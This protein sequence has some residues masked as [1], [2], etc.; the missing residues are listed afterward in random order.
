MKKVFSLMIFFFVLCMAQTVYAA[1]NVSLSSNKSS[2]KVGEEFSVSVSLS[3]A[4]VA[5]LTARITIDTSKV[6]YVSGPSNSSFRNGRMIYTW[7]DPNGGET[8]K[9]SGVLATFKLKAKAAGSAGFSVSGDFYTPEETAVNP[10]FSGTTVTII[11]EAPEKPIE[12]EVPQAPTT[13]EVPNNP[14]LPSNP[15]VPNTPETPTTPEVPST[16]SQGTTTTP[17]TNP[18]Q[19]G[20]TNLSSNANLKSL[21]L[22]VQGMTPAFQRDVLQYGIVVNETVTDVDVLAVAEDSNSSIQITGNHG[23]QMGNNTI[24]ITVTAQNG[25]K[26]TYTISVTKTNEAN[27]A[28]SFLENLAIENVALTPDFRYD[29]LEYTAEIESNIESLNVLAV[30]QRE[31]AKVVIEGRENLQ[32]GENKITVTVTAEDGITT[33]NYIIKVYRKTQ[34]EEQQEEA[35][36][37]LE[38]Q[39]QEKEKETPERKQ[40]NAFAHAIL[41]SVITVGVIILIGMLVAKYYKEK[42]A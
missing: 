24:Q 28:N 32:F 29:V 1:G 18:V 3:N 15:E 30:P 38:G 2:V 22:D 26:Q 7:T 27:L 36:V 31:G 10:V 34:E 19:E 9:T 40:G 23:L 16:P 11:E 12:P 35:S 8:P 5:S 4:T 41:A 21:R 37:V 14:E 42:K 13:P 33:K 6:D 25:K 39:N 20:N 17:N